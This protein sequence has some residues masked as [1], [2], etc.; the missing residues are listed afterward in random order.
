MSASDF[1]DLAVV[2]LTYMDGGRAAELIDLVIEGGLGPRQLVVVQNA[3]IGQLDLPSADITLLKTER[4][5]GYAGGMNMGISHCLAGGARKVLLMTHDAR[6]TAGCVGALVTAL[7]AHDDYGVLAPVLRSRDARLPFSAGGYL[8]DSG[9]FAHNLVLADVEDGIKS[10]DWVDGSIMLIRSE[11]FTAAGLF[12]ERFFMYC[13]DVE[14]CARVRESGWRVGIVADAEAGQSSGVAGRPG[15][16]AY[17]TTRNGL[18]VARRTGGTAALARS[19]GR[20]GRTCW[21]LFRV[22][23]GPNSGKEARRLARIALPA[24]IEGVAHFAVG[25][26]GPPRQGLPGLGD[27]MVGPANRSAS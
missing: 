3:A 17:L 10:V 21:E 27:V 7:D 13:D 11:A 25:R 12:D 26:W 22:A 18:E 9:A 1:P 24:T 14:I 19:L 6:P 23:F 5:V 20:I 8:S 4:N 15:A 2:I 16:Y